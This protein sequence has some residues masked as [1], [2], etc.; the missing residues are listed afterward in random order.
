M[1]LLNTEGEDFGV[2]DGQE[3]NQTFLSGN[4]DGSVCLTIDNFIDTA[5]ENAEFYI[6]SIIKDDETVSI[7]NAIITIIDNST[8]K[9]VVIAIVCKKGLS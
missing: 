2:T 5:I 6:V 8:G 7:D 3:L 1:V 9:V 4:S